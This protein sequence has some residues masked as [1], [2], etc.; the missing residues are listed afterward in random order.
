MS[1]VTMDPFVRIPVGPVAVIGIVRKVLG[2]VGI[3]SAI[4]PFVAVRI[5]AVLAGRMPIVSSP[6]V[7][8]R[9]ALLPVPC[10]ANFLSVETVACRFLKSV[11]TGTKPIMI[12]A[13][14]PA[15]IPAAVM[16][17]CNIRRNAMTGIRSMLIN[18]RTNARLL[19]AA[20]AS[21]RLGSSAMMGTRRITTVAGHSV[22]ETSVEI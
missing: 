11:M 18:V 5:R 21:S 12:L 10:S 14:M 1:S 13:P 2:S 9:W 19:A 17:L 7:A 15:E 3:L 8:F 16:A 4:F 20:T 6:I 22:G